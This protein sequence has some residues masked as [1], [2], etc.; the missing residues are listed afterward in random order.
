[1]HKSQG[2]F[3][4]FS[5]LT[6]L[7]D[8]SSFFK[9]RVSQLKPE[10]LKTQTDSHKQLHH[11]ITI[12]HRDPEQKLNPKCEVQSRSRNQNQTTSIN[13]SKAGLCVTVIRYQLFPTKQ[14]S[15]SLFLLLSH[16]TENKFQEFT[17]SQRK[18]KPNRKPTPHFFSHYII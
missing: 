8:Q 2:N 17:Q 9:G 5:C 18:I 3:S 14:K 13:F 10:Y 12:S 15:N 4:S 11:L 6:S 16:H 1:M 7:C